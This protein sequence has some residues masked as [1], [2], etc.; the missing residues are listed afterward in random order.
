MFTNI[1]YKYNTENP[2]VDF[3]KSLTVTSCGV[4]EIFS[5]PTI[6]TERP[7]GRDDWQLLYIDSGQVTFVFDGEEKTLDKGSLI[8]YCPQQPQYYYYHKSHKPVVYWIHFSGREVEKILNHYK[9][10]I[11]QN[12][13]YIGISNN[14]PAIFRQI[15]NE[16]QLGKEKY[17]EMLFYKLHEL[18]LNIN[19]ALISISV[20]R[21]DISTLIKQ[22]KTYF[23]ENYNQNIN[24]TN[25][26]NN[27]NITPCWFIKKFKEITG[28][29]PAQY[30]L[31]VRLNA[32]K[33][34]LR[35]SKYNVSETA[36][37]V[38]Y[39]NAFYFSRLFTKHFGIS[40][41]EFRKEQT[42]ASLNAN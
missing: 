16:L 11:E 39:D 6:A 3:S 22:A 40:P 38:G 42:K 28:L 33:N 5:G 35:Y 8:L 13:F 2:I 37:S 26:A 23:N 9:I 31:K 21:N 14:L 32:A 27:L 18:F 10:F 34:L 17:E 25:Y 41:S 30:I 12:V 15:I 36:E 1:A 4:Y 20:N 7:T 19:R 24:I 29:T